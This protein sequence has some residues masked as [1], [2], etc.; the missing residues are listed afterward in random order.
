MEAT[1]PLKWHLADASRLRA[2]ANLVPL[3]VAMA[4]WAVFLPTTD[5][6]RMTDMGLISVLPPAVPLAVV[7][8]IASAAWQLR[9]D[10]PSAPFLALHLVVLIVFLYAIPSMIEGQPRFAVTYIHVGLA[11]YIARTGTVA[12]G[13]EARFDWPGFFILAAFLSQAIGLR[14]SMDLAGWAPVYLNLLY[15]APL[16]LIFRSITRDV[17]LVWAGLFLFAL[18]NWV[19]QDYF[20][21][22]GLNYFLFLSIVGLVLTYFRTAHPGSARLRDWLG[23][24]RRAGS[25]LAWG[26]SFVAPDQLPAVDLSPARKAGL[27]LAIVVIFGFVVF[28]HQLTPFFTVA[29]LLALVAF[30]R[31]RLRTLPILMG[32]MAVVW[33]S[34]MTVPF[35]SG[36]VAGLVSEF[37]QISGSFGAN[38]TGRLSGSA[39]HHLVVMID[40][41]FS[42]SIWTTAAVGFFVRLRDGRRDLSM[43]ILAGAPVP[44]VAAQAYGGE[45]VLRLFLFTLPFMAILA[46]GTV[47]GRPKAVPSLLKTCA[48]LVGCG[49]IT[50]GFLVTRYGNER[51]DLMTTAE[52]TGVQQ[53]YGIAPPGSLL[54][55]TN[56]NLPWRSQGFEEYD[57]VALADTILLGTPQDVATQMAKTSHIESYLILTTSEQAAAELFSGISKSSWDDFVA[58]IAASPEFRLVYQ[59]VDTRIFELVAQPSEVSAPLGYERPAA[60]PPTRAVDG[61]RA[62]V[63]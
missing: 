25:L 43:I 17:R 41:A 63:S 24:R 58:Q 21:P 47:Y 8:T 37:G 32:V 40:M 16:T 59:N 6:A 28:S 62:A 9:S 34:Y 20:S 35:L 53:I 29:A 60:G 12:P 49:A 54:A 5:L 55:S 57:Y 36:H 44:L 45:M 11:E 51:M 13:L 38:V 42:V 56:G 1:L 33:V 30:N 61:L 14:D 18:S 22:Q 27:T 50:L 31:I 15:M 3:A 4:L 10:R 46:A 39:D 48:A 2:A 7:L 26:Y 52:V 23:S 19:G